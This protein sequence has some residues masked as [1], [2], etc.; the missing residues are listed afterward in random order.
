M[1]PLLAC[2]LSCVPFA[3]TAWCLPAVSLPI[4]CHLFATRKIQLPSCC[5]QL[6]HNVSRPSSG[7]HH[8]QLRQTPFSLDLLHATE[9]QVSVD[10]VGELDHDSWK[11]DRVEAHEAAGLDQL[12]VGKQT[13]HRLVYVIW[14]AVR[15]RSKTTAGLRKTAY[16]TVCIIGLRRTI[17][18]VAL[19]GSPANTWILSSRQV[20]MCFSWTGV[21]RPRG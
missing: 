10:E 6:T 3:L 21:I 12:L 20:I 11:V 19:L 5:N 8:L 14:A 4:F 15:Y 2:R 1:T 7:H 16:K 13:A 9:L 17:S 18:H